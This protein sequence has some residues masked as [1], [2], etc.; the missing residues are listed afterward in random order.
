MNVLFLLISL[1][2]LAGCSSLQ[3][4]SYE[5]YSRDGENRVIAQGQAAANA[6]WV[7]ASTA[8]LGSGAGG[9]SSPYA[10]RS[11]ASRPDVLADS[12]RRIYE[13]AVRTTSGAISGSITESIRQT[14]R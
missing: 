12:T 4:S 14:L 6:A 9:P 7:H 3:P 13:D 1:V 2:L 10:M 5:N 11:N 8:T